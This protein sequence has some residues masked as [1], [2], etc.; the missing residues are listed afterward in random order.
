MPRNF[1][2]NFI[3]TINLHPGAVS[4]VDTIVQR[5]C[6][7]FRCGRLEV[8]EWRG[9]GNGEVLGLIK[10]YTS[11]GLEPAFDLRGQGQ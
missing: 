8:L 5:Y 9:C 3:V 10:T 7:V 4:L 11:I 6:T 1:L 2:N